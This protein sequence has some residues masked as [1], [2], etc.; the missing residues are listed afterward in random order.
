MTTPCIT[1]V[2][3]MA[4]NRVIGIDNRLPWHLPEDLKHFK[5]VTLGKPVIMGRKT[6][7]SI[8]RPLP[9]RRNIVV[10]RQRDWSVPGVEVAHSLEAALA[11]VSAAASACIIG[12]ADLYRQALPLAHRLELTEIA[13]SYQGDAHFPDFGSGGWQEVQREAHRSEQGLDYAFVSYLRG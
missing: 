9:G 3:A 10:T 5:A 1:L 13:G 12:G 7:D 6:Y 2:A 11:L 8:G 4:A